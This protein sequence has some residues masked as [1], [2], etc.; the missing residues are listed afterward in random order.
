MGQQLVNV[1]R[2]NTLLLI[3]LV[4]LAGAFLFLRTRSTPVASVDE[5]DA[6]LAS[7]QPVII[8]FYSNA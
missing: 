2:Q 7:G 5:F 4:G 6:L 3:V 8:E 1:L